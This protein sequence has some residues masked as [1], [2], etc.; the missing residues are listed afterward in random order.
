MLSRLLRFFCNQTNVLPFL[1]FTL[2]HISNSMVSCTHR[3]L[4]CCVCTASLAFPVLPRERTLNVITSFS[5]RDTA[6]LSRGV[7]GS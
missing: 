1:S 5:Y 7:E 4:L 2:G 3:R 6:N